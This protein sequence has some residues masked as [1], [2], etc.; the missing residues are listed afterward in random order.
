MT[1]QFISNDGINLSGIEVVNV[2]YELDE[3][4]KGK[5][6]EQKDSSRIISCDYVFLAIGFLNPKIEGMLEELEVQLDNRKNVSCADYQTSVPGV[7]SAGD[8]R[9]GQ[10]LVVWAISEGR[11]AAAAVDEYLMGEESVLKSNF[12]SFLKI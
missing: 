1:K 10:S 7:F 12:E 4:G 8:M 9:R 2:S 6:V 11:E 5:M 3:Q